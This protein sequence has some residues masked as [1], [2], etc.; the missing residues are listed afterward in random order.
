MQ[1][2]LAYPAESVAPVDIR[3]P[4]PEQRGRVLP[5]YNGYGSLADSAE[6]CKHLI[7]QPPRKDFYKLI[8]KGNVVLRFGASFLGS[9]THPVSLDHR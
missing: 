9:P 5:P 6:N 1:E 7:P 2:S 4:V 8:N 3:E